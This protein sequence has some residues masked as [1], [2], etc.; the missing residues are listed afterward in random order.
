[1]A[2]EP[3]IRAATPKDLAAAIALLDNADL[4]VADLDAGKFEDF[5]VATIDGTTA[6]FIGLEQFGSLGLLRSLVVAP[7][8]RDAGL[9]RRLVAA[10]ESRAADAGV[11]EMWLLTID[12]DRWFT[13]IDYSR[14]DRSEVPA[15]I[16]STEEFT[17]LCPGS[18]VLMK[19]SL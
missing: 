18:A 3:E 13:I 7:E 19:K 2:G 17:S 11:R 16:A 12:A 5:L 4:P 8:Y 10:L 9:G 15:A 6:G 1:M 14:C